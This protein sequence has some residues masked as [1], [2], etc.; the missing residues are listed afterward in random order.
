[1]YAQLAEAYLQKARDT[2]DPTLLRKARKNLRR[3]I[4]IQP[5]FHAFKIFTALCNF[6]HRFEEALV[7]GARAAE[8]SP[9]DTAVTAML[10]EASLGLGRYAAAKKL[11]P[12]NGAEPPDFYAAFS[13]A[14]WLASQDRVD[15]AVDAFRKAARFARADHD[16]ELVAY[17]WVSAAGILLDAGK[18]DRA[19]E[20]LVKAST[21][22]PCNVE[23]QIHK[24][25]LLEADGQISEALLLYAKVIAI[26]NNAEVHARAFALAKRLGEDLRAQKHFKAAE[27]GFLKALQ[28]G[29]VYTL[30]ALARLYD[31]AD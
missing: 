25:E 26:S 16:R 4:E 23:L 15:Q 22:D 19:R 27:D 11:L 21:L 18:P 13:Q 6:S 29:E 8:G 14:R 5:N 3:S 20:H 2:H 28:A 1:M 30:G 7:W 24:A 9:G 10:V 12:P 31:A 17:C